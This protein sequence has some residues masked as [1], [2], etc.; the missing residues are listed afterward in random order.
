MIGVE[1]GTSVCRDWT[2]M[3]YVCPV[4]FQCVCVSVSGLSVGLREG[5]CLRICKWVHSLLC[6]NRWP[7]FQEIAQEVVQSLWLS[8]YMAMLWCVVVGCPK[9]DT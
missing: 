7:S 3:S 9:K 6:S 4:C 8:D 2:H 5:S 1:G